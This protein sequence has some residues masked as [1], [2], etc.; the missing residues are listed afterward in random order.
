MKMRTGNALSYSISGIAALRTKPVARRVAK[1]LPGL[2]P[3]LKVAFVGN[4]FN[5]PK[6]RQFPYPLL[7]ESEERKW[8]ATTRILDVWRRLNQFAV[9]VYIEELRNNDVVFTELFG[10]DGAAYSVIPCDDELEV[11]DAL[12][13]HFDLVDRRVKKEGIK[14][15]YYVTL[16]TEP[17]KVPDIVWAASPKLRHL[18]RSEIILYAERELQL[19]GK[20]FANGH[21]QRAHP[22]EA[23][24]SIDHISREAAQ[25]IAG[26]VRSHLVK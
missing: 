6:R 25:F 7:C 19:H 10:C 23:T 24:R 13:L 21:G 2:L 22:I 15:P 26:D 3:D 18:Q 8:H 20:Y 17:N 14:P 12:D 4:P 9:D 1:M 16:V 11:Q 5:D